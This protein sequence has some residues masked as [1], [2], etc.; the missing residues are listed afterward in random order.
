MTPGI[1]IGTSGW[2]YQHW[3]G[4]F[5]PDQL[6]PREWLKYYMR[7]FETVEV[8]NTF[9]K[10]PGKNV[11]RD[12]YEMT[13]ECFVFSVKASRYITHMKKLKDPVQPIRTLIGNVTILK[14]KLGP[15]LFQLPPRWKNNPERLALFL[16]AMPDDLRIA[17]EFRDES[18]WNPRIT[19]ILADNNA[20]F[21]IYELAGRQSPK[22]VTADFVYIRL[23]GPSGAYEGSYSIRVLSDWAAAISG[24][25]RKG[26]S[27]F[28]YFDND[29]CAY[30]VR[31][32]QILKKMT[33]SNRSDQKAETC[34][35]DVW[36]DSGTE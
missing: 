22:W 9:Y 19:G 17:F 18:W 29:Q 31:N 10:L 15:L 25:N 24:W 32:A 30:A 6:T 1:K 21:C 26:L 2:N 8:N 34:A 35:G 27:V 13:S 7:H 4:A 28:C 14:D 16:K 12:W 36:T 23:H 11:F 20:S 3:K 5:Y 33:G